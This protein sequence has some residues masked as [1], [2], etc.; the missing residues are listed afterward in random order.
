M[1]KHAM[2]HMV[3]Y[4]TLIVLYLIISAWFLYLHIF[5]NFDLDSTKYDLKIW[6]SVY[7]IIALFGGIVGIFISRKWGGHKSI[8]G[9]AILFFALGLL[10]QVFGQ[11]FDSYLNVIKNVE[12]PYPALGDIGFFGSV[13]SYIIGAFYMLKSVGFKFSLRSLKGKLISITIPLLLLVSS[14]FFFL[15][16]YEFDW[17]DK[18]KIFLDLGYPF[19][20]A[21]YVSIAILAFLVSRN[22]LGGI[23]KKPIIFLIF[24]LFFQ[25][26]CEFVFL[27]QANAGTWYAGGI[28]DFMYFTSYFI[29][30][31][32]LL[33]LGSVVEKIKNS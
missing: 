32:A 5:L 23:M 4:K 24:A 20:E 2:R 16:G 9:K 6:A 31:L 3:K 21:I 10:L 26:S 14:Y 12:I 17:T 22:Y 28:N 25:Y 19:G 15:Q 11:S 7:Q 8:V 30:S 18:V 13:V 1:T 29:M 27:Y 33:E